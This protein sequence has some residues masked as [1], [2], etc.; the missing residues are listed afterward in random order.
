MK[1]KISLLTILILFLILFPTNAA[2]YGGNLKIKVEQ[3]PFNLNPIY[4][5]NETALMINNQIFDTLISYNSQ[6]KLTANLAESWQVNKDSTVYNFKLKK[7][8]YFH[9]Y[10]IKE[11]EV[12]L[13]ER[14]VTAEDWKWSL[15]YL[16]AARNKSP[17]AELLAKIKGY[18]K[19]RQGKSKEI[20]GIRVLD[21]Y[22]LEIELKQS[23]A[24]FIYNLA[25][26]AAVVM[27]AEAVLNKDFNF[28][29]TP[30]GTGPF[31][32]G[33]FFKNK[34]TL[35]K[36]DNYWK[37]NYQ[38]QNTPYLNQI[39]INFVEGKILKNNLQ[40]F[41]LY[42]L[43]SEEFSA[44]QQQKNNF[45]D[46]QIMKFE[47]SY[48]YFAAFNY[49]SDLHFNSS[50]MNF[51]ESIR[52]IINKNDFPA[53]LNFNNLIL[54]GASSNNQQLLA[55]IRENLVKN[56]SAT[57]DNELNN[58]S[59]TINNSKTAIKIAE[60]MKNQLKSKDI[61]LEVKKYNWAEYFKKVKSQ[62]IDSQLFIMSSKYSSRFQF[63]Y[64]NFYSTSA[65]NYFGYHNSRV[66]NMIDYLKLI[67]S[68]QNREKAYE[69][70]TEI[71]INDNPFVF[72]LQG[73]DS[74]LISSKI[75]NEELFKNVYSKYNFEMLYFEQ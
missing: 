42:Q 10:K 7:N 39:E 51:K 1:V 68:R 74:Y 17:Y 73:A 29:L 20:A 63:I 24:P 58:L 4:A 28:S 41:D 31:K 54:P 70:I 56:D 9:S 49:K 44:F 69:I 40:K 38:D 48:I 30:V 23:Y 57:L 3:R 62:N 32:F 52:D 64:D 46:Y 5:A 75:K 18:D 26:R 11:G 25:K 35:L 15:E 50:Q 12:P 47:N 27:P 61:K 37:N 8:I 13:N 22:N 14:S 60:Y 21:T 43:N 53:A 66:D 67:S 33:G 71:L 45:S 19:F 65:K 6:G 55:K 59:L 16:A 34:V 36:N 2:N 72:L